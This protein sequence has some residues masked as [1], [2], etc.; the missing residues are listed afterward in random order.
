[1]GC[2][3]A[4]HTD[5]GSGSKQATGGGFTTASKLLQI[6]GFLGPG[7]NSRTEALRSA[8]FLGANLIRCAKPLGALHASG[9]SWDATHTI[10]ASSS[11]MALLHKAS[12]SADSA[13]KR[14][15]LNI[16]G[17]IDGRAFTRHAQSA[18]VKARIARA[19][20]AW[21]KAYGHD[22]AA[23]RVKRSAKT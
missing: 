4:I 14:R 16:V 7:A 17:A 3:R 8:T 21:E 20:H 6:R 19:R 13:N 23:A 10:T 22:P 12:T 5:C 18:P 9:L 2:A 11:A 15:A 1:V